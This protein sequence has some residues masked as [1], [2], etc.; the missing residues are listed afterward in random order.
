M[1]YLILDPRPVSLS[2]Q[3]EMLREKK[4]HGFILCGF[5][6]SVPALATEFGFNI[7]PQHSEGDSQMSCILAIANGAL[8]PAIAQ[9]LETGKPMLWATVRPDLDSIG[10]MAIQLM[11][12]E[13]G[14]ETL[15]ACADRVSPEVFERVQRIHRAD[16]SRTDKWEK[17]PL[18]SQDTPGYEHNESLGGIAKAVADYKIPLEQRVQ[19]MYAWLESGVEPEGYREAW[20]KEWDEI[21]SALESGA[22]RVNV[23][24]SGK[25]AIVNS[26]LRAATSIGYAHAPVLICYNPEFPHN[27]KE[28]VFGMK[29]SVCQYTEGYADLTAFKDEMKKIE[30]GWGGSPTIVCSPQGEPSTLSPE[31]VAEVLQKH[32]L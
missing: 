16:C 19:W 11:I 28:G 32:L 21:K 30:E 6:V 4:E 23:E 12:N 24:A 10:A 25:Y 31:V 3:Q 9:R 29:Y 13:C 8:A 2:Q 27:P 7:D 20:L 22:T 1:L 5:E 14:E 17:R 18:F 15:A 26:K